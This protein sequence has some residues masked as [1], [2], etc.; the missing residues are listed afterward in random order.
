MNDVDENIVLGNLS[1]E[2]WAEFVKQAGERYSIWEN[3]P[4]N[5]AMN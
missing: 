2:S 4:E 1:H 3:F 5:P